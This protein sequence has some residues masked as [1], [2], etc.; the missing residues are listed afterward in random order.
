MGRKKILVLLGG[1]GY[2]GSVITEQAIKEGYKVK[3]IDRFFFGT[4][5]LMKLFDHPSLI[6]IEKDIRNLEEKDV[7]NSFALIDLAG[8]SNDPSADLNPVLTSSINYH[9]SVH[10]AKIAK[11]AGVERYLYT[12]SCSVYGNNAGICTETTPLRPL[13]TYANAKA[14]A[15]QK[16]LSL[17]DQSFSVTALRNATAFGLSNRMR[18][19]LAIN[20]MTFFAVT[21]K[22]ITING[23]GKQRRPFIHVS[24]IS[25]IYHRVLKLPKANIRSQ[26]LNIGMG[27]YT[28]SEVANKIKMALKEEIAIKY[29]P[30]NV[31]HRD[32]EVCLDKLFSVLSY[33]PQWTVEQGAIEIA[34]ALREKH[35][36]ASSETF[37]VKTLSKVNETTWK[38]PIIYTI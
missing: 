37:T 27:N 35:V 28:I 31:D 8:I 33:Q 7:E 25:E 10:A 1:A 19:D 11:I 34:K 32:Y 6:M 26:I 38:F 18:F 17:S 24:D 9:G 36:T 22:E 5:S 21:K 14:K 3:V 30:V 23:N 29:S 16:I 12:S 20:I 2:I 4:H 13:T 15:E